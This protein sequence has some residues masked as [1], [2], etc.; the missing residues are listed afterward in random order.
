M[1]R[2]SH[3]KDEVILIHASRRSEEQAINDIRFWQN[4]NDETRS[5]AAWQIARAVHLLTRKNEAELQM[6]KSK[7]R[8]AHRSEAGELFDLSNDFVFTFQK[9][10]K[11]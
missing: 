6:E 3:W 11:N 2:P 5:V 10:C 9:N 4:Q 7:G 8:V 1:M